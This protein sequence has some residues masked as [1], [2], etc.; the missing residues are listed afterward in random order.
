M[1]YI[2]VDLEATC[3]E[4]RDGKR[5]EIIEIGAVSVDKQLKIVGEFGEFVKPKVNP[6]LSDF[7]IQL[8]SIE[9]SNIDNASSF[10]EV[11]DL[12]LRWIKS[13][14][15]NYILCS[16]GYYDRVQFKNDCE[17]HG[18]NQDWS[19]RHISLK[20]QYGKI[21]GLRRPPSMKRALK[22]EKMPLDGTHHRGIDD[23]RNITKIFQKYYDKWD[24][25]ALF[26]AQ[27][28]N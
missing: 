14:S 20:H 28:H 22:S 18:L 1:N 26:S 17:L 23:A 10:L 2:I 27:M 12:F 6:E 15:G 8:T 11:I 3:W 16:W 7:C 19:N 4:N 21:K 9:Q 25:D 13:F 5:N 24:F